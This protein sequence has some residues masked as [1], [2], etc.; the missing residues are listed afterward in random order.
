MSDKSND[1]GVITVRVPAQLRASFERLSTA[2]G[3]TKSYLALEA[4]SEY[5]QREAWQIAAIQEGVEAADKGQFASDE[6]VEQRFKNWGVDVKA[7]M[8]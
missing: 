5:M 6:E 2:T 8:D 7:K 3:R 4:L 1:S